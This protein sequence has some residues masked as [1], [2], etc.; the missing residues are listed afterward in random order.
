MLFISIFVSTVVGESGASPLKYPFGRQTDEDKLLPVCG[1]SSNQQ[2]ATA[3]EVIN[4]VNDTSTKQ[5]TQSRTVAPFANFATN[6]PTC[7][8]KI[9]TTFAN[10][11]KTLV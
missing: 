4:N 11:A 7:I 3:Q 9:A 10:V 2:A 1:Y 6:E 8:T 5:I